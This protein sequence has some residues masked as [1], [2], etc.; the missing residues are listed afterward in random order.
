[1]HAYLICNRWQPT[2]DTWNAVIIAGLN[3]IFR[4]LFGVVL[5]VRVAWN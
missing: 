3:K 1:M 2:S 5:I 4:E